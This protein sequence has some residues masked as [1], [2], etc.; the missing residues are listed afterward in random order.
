MLI[1]TTKPLVLVFDL[2]PHDGD[3]D[4][5][6]SPEDA[7]RE[8]EETGD[9]GP[10][11]W[12]RLALCPCGGYTLFEQPVDAVEC[13]GEEVVEQNHWSRGQSGE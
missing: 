1:L 5:T 9:L 10:C 11:R 13:D 2:A 7:E 4:D 12:S 6:C 8:E 3:E